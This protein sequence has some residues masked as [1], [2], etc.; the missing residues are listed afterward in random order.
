LQFHKH[1][2]VE[3]LKPLVKHC[4]EYFRGSFENV[5][6]RCATPKLGTKEAAKKIYVCWPRNSHTGSLQLSKKIDEFLF[7]IGRM[8]QFPGIDVQPNPTFGLKLRWIN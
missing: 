5:A 7:P 2:L 3:N 8:T 1:I 4:L 6:V